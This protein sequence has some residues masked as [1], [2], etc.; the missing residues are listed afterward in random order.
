LV[1]D[2]IQLGEIELTREELENLTDAE[3]KELQKKLADHAESARYAKAEIYQESATDQQVAFHSAKNRVRLFFG[4]NRC[5]AEGT[6]IAT[7]K[8]PIKIEDIKVGDTV[9]DETGGEISVLK[10]FCN[11]LKVVADLTNRGRTWASCTA[12]HV[13]LTSTW[14]SDPRE[15]KSSELARDVGV[16]R[17]TFYTPLGSVVEPHAYAIGALL[18][19]GCGREKGRESIHISSPDNLIPDKIGTVLGGFAHEKRHEGNYTWKIPTKDCNHYDDWIRGRY[20][21]EKIVD[22]EV[23]KTWDRDSLVSFVAGVLDTDGSVYRVEDKIVVQ[24]S[25][26][27]KIVLEAVR[28][29][30]LAL[31][32]VDFKLTSDNRDKYKNGPVYSLYCQN[33]F[34]TREMLLELDS[35]LVSPQKKWR[36]EYGE[37]FGKRTRENA[38]SMSWGKNK[39]LENTYDIH[40]DSKTNLY[41]LANGLVTH[42]S[43]KTTAG[44]LETYWLATGKHAYRNFRTP[45]KMCIVLQD[46]Q[47]HAQDVIIP[48][49]KEWF[50]PDVILETH[51]NQAKVDVKYFIRGGS[52]ID[53]KSHDQDIKVFEGSDYDVVWFDEP[54]PQAIFKALWRGLTDRRGIAYFTGTPIVEPWMFDLYKKAEQADNRGMYWY[55]FSEIHDNKTNIGE[56]D[57]KEGER[58]IAEFLDALDPDEREAREKGRFLHM[59][60]LIFKNWDRTTHLIEPFKWPVSWPVMISVD[61]HPRKPWAICFL[62]L[63][64]SGNKILLRSDLV[65]GVVEDIAEHILWAKNEI[66]TD[67]PASKIRIHSCWIDN[68]ANVESMI[69]SNG[70]NRGVRILDELNQ[71]VYPTIPKFKPAPKNVDD[72]IQI[73]KSWLKPQETKYGERPTFMA[74]HNTENRDFIYEIEHY[75]WAKKRGANRANYKNVPVKENDDILDTIMQLC[76]VLGSKKDQDQFTNPPKV[77]NYLGR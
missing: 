11:G 15:R 6:L 25:M 24:F 57:P 4:G 9:Y 77:H 50:P 3:L 67:N 23:L 26:Q 58:R 40:V 37:I 18:G 12:D 13:W 39:R 14:R 69:K 19:G 55:I 29:A 71:L 74:F 41:C 42:N 64:P 76:L 27:A 17:R 20:S 68:Y 66:E 2:T 63:T 16:E 34:Y 52:V 73:F 51:K 7:P 36:P 22:L 33:I 44:T 54:P 32:Q 59:S 56:G 60:G 47:T 49:I 61:P 72:K 62:G 30:C 35:C 65:D 8:G 45:I 53:I 21:H 1:E 31:W 5:L 43:G 46:F 10:T 48:K 28:Y 38:V 75:V 70:S